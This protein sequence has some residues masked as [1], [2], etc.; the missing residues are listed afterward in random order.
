MGIDQWREEQ[1]WPLPDT[2]YES[3]YLDGSGR[4]TGPPLQGSELTRRVAGMEV[5]APLTLAA[6][7]I[8]A[9]CAVRLLLNRRRL[10]V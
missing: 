3:W 8:I 6:V 2:T 1:A 10:P 9:A 7:L 5:L 4:A